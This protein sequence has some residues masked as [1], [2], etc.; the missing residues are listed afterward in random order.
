MV[1]IKTNQTPLIL[2]M[3]Q[4]EVNIEDFT[5]HKWINHDSYTWY[6]Q[7]VNIIAPDKHFYSSNKKNA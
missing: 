4:F 3:D 7:T 1:T 2:E 6:M 5:R